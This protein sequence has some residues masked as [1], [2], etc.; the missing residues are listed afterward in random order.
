MASRPPRAAASRHAAGTLASTQAV[1]AATAAATGAPGAMASSLTSTPGGV[2]RSVMSSS[3]V[4]GW[5][6][7]LEGRQP[8]LE[9]LAARRELHGEGLVVELVVECLAAAAVHQ[10]LGQAEGDG[11]GLGEGRDQ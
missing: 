2:C 4:P 3:P 1:V 6:L 10:P 5:T 9:V 7:L 8:L 11:G